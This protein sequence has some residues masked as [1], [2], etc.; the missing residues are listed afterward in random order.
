[1]RKAKLNLRRETM[2]IVVMMFVLAGASAVFGTSVA[3]QDPSA[4]DKGMKQTNFYCNLRA[5]SADQHHRQ[6]ELSRTLVSLRRSARELPDGYEFELPA[7][8]ATVQAAAEWAVMEK[9]C[10]PFLRIDLRLEADQGPFWL[11]LSGKE[12]VK[13]FIRA[14]FTPM[15]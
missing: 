1:M 11:R 9:L 3:A 2:K 14:D 12:G 8:S 5:L 6:Q 15:F 10:C 4:P 7:D 13:Q